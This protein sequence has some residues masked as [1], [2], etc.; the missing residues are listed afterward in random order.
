MDLFARNNIHVQP[1][2]DVFNIDVDELDNESQKCVQPQN[3]GV[4]LKD[5]QLT[6]LYRAIEYENR[7][8]LLKEYKRIETRVSD[9]DCFYTNIG[10]LADRVG[11]GKSYVILALI[12]SNHIYDNHRALIRSS[13]SNNVSFHLKNTQTSA[14]TNVI[15]IPFNLCVQWERYIETFNGGLRF[16]VINKSR[17]IADMDG[18][19]QETSLSYDIFLVTSTFYNRFVDIS[20]KENMKYQ[21]IIFDEADTI[22][23]SSCYNMDAAFYWFITASYGNILYPRGYVKQDGNVGR[24]IWYAHGLKS[25]GF[26]RNVFIDLYYTVPRDIFKTLVIKN[27]ELYVQQSINLPSIEILT[28]TCKTPHSINILNGIVDK[29]II[30]C[31]NAGDTER[32]LQYVNP[33]QKMTEQ[34]IIHAIIGK[35]TVQLSNVRVK[36]SMLEHLQFDDESEYKKE[37]NSLLL[38]EAELL[39]NIETIKSRV[40]NSDMCNICCDAYE[41]KTVVKCCQNSFCFKCI[42]LWMNRKAVCPLCKT[43]LTNDMLFVTCLHSDVDA[44]TSYHYKENDQEQTLCGICGFRKD[45][46]KLN[47]LELILKGRKG[48][49]ILIFSEFENTFDN[50]VPLLNKLHIQYDSLKGN[51]VHVN[52]IIERYKSD[53]IDVLMVNTRYY[54]SGLNL[55]N[56]TDIIMFHKFNTEIEKQVIGR[57]QRIGRQTNLNVWYLLHENE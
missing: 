22:N 43:D 40:E 52:S 29:N 10:I 7:P 33:S 56:T 13:G 30:H 4:T 31:L 26:I 41:N 42:Q 23:I 5:H 14:K 16:K 1:Q 20:R 28:V 15:V 11:S 44:S 3:I 24:F 2:E 45:K 48:A 32:A 46:T 35:Y 8:I 21:R 6:L 51:G 54:G 39:K 18:N 36:I 37:Q 50:I 17:I 55:E 49:K 38:K 25:T 53:V 27:S 19:V 34:N 12:Y 57:A 47:N 9:D